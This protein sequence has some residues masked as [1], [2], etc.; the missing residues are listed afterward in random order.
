MSVSYEK[1][2]IKGGYWA[3]RY[4]RSGASLSSLF[5]INALL[6]P[7]V[8]FSGYT[9]VISVKAMSG[10]GKERCASGDGRMGGEGRRCPRSGTALSPASAN[11]DNA[12]P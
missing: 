11:T 5:A 7:R 12:A 6:L 10:G 8:S 4:V 2:R 3:Y 1:G 9:S